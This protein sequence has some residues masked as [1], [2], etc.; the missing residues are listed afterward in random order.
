MNNNNTRNLEQ[1]RALTNYVPT[2]TSLHSWFITGFSDGESCFLIII[3]KNNKL[4]LG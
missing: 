3:P 1:D 2:G 4:K